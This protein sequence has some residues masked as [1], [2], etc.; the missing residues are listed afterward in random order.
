MSQRKGNSTPAAAEAPRGKTGGK[1]R[2]KGD[3]DRPEVTIHCDGACRGNPGVGGYGA[4][5]DRKGSDRKG[6]EETVRGAVARTTNNRMELTAA[7]EGLRSLDGN[8]RVKIFTDSQYLRNGITSWIHNWLQRGW[9]TAA[10]K[11]VCNR[12]LWEELHA[13]CGKHDIQWEWV[14]GHSGHDLNERA[15]DLANEAIDEFLAQQ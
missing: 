13:L 15:D 14:R 8:F 6:R 4:I 10:R 12:D 11:S 3:P 1:T 7:I 2:G 5:I 9:K